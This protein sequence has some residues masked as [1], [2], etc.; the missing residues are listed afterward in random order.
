[1]NDTEVLL[2]PS[3]RGLRR[4]E[5]ALRDVESGRNRTRALGFLPLHFINEEYIPSSWCCVDRLPWL[6]NFSEH[7]Q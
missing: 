5:V 4:Y 1:M 3:L 2:A 7:A 6:A